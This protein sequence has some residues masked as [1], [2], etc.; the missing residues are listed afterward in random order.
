LTN[1]EITPFSNAA[2]YCPTAENSFTQLPG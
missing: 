2:Y 1:T